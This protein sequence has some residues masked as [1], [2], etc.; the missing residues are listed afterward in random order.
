MPKAN[1]T[2]ALLRTLKPRAGARVSEYRDGEVSGLEIRIWESGSKSWRF[3]YTRRSDGR[4]RVVGLG[5]YPN[6][7]LK[8]ARRKARRLQTEVED[9]DTR[10]D[11]AG[12]RHARLRAQT[13]SDIADDWLER[14]ARPNKSPRAVR[15]DIS[16]LDRHVRPKIGRMRVTEIAKRDVIKLLD[17]VAAK[18]DGRKGRKSAG[19]MTHRPNR[20]FELVRAIFRWAAS[21]DLLTVDPTF[22]LAPPIRKERPRER[23]LS[24]DEIKRLWEALDKT[25]VERRHTTG[26]PIGSRAIGEDDIPMTRATALALKLALVTGQRIGEVTGIALSELALNDTAPLWTVPGERSKN[27]QSNRVPLSP[28]AVWLIQ[29]ALKFARGGAWLFPSPKGEGPIDAHTPTKGLERAAERSA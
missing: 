7:S 24:P 23:D 26:L 21:R 17:E 3:H 27:A 10:A 1:F 28:L 5:S 19:K 15:D 16:M 8:E 18:P 22:G 20:V 14:H 29:E 11:P 13:F 12:D 2:D 9:L 25:P 6:T 4:R